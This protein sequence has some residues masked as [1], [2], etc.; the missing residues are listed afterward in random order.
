[1]IEPQSVPAGE[2]AV[3]KT[4]RRL[5]SPQAEI[6]TAL[7]IMLNRDQRRLESTKMLECGPTLRNSEFGTPPPSSSAAALRM[8]RQR[9][10]HTRPETLLRSELHRRGLRYYVHRRPLIGSRHTADIVFPGVRV[11][12]DVRGCYW[13][14]CPA[15]GS[16]PKANAS[17]WAEKFRRNRERDAAAETR[18]A[19]AGWRL[20]IV[21]EHEDHMLAAGR[22]EAAVRS[23]ARAS[24]N[25]AK[26]GG[27]ASDR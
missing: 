17:W 10:Q 11:A 6:G 8:R 9:Q 24:L 19:A 25:M 21:W 23:I 3:W 1:M 18:F 2:P 7:H 4:N 14:S 27:S 15:H 12:V 22:V 26:L 5:G 13:H 16:L 20:V